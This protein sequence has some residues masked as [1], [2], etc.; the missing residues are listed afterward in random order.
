MKFLVELGGGGGNIPK[1]LH[2]VY[3]DGA[4]KMTALYK[5]VVHCKERRELLEDDPCLG[6]PASTH[7]DENM[8]RIDELIATNR[9]ISN[10]YIAETF[11]I[12]RETV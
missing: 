5:W 9:R 8:K 10:C 4:L 3:G 6:R 12:Y 7:N 11:G 1:K 2:T